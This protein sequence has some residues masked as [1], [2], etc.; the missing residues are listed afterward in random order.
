MDGV[1]KW[2]IP[3]LFDINSSQIHMSGLLVS[4]TPFHFPLPNPDVILNKIW[5]R[6]RPGRR[7]LL[8]D[9]A[10]IWSNKSLGET[11]TTGDAGGSFITVSLYRKDTTGFSS[12]RVCIPQAWMATRKA[13]A[14]SDDGDIELTGDKRQI[15]QVSLCPHSGRLAGIR[16]RMAP[17]GVHQIYELAIVDLLPPHIL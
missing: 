3:R 6:S 9:M 17:D 10:M 1:Y 8:P 5:Y 13:M 11:T 4:N 15:Y 16:V 12:T 2:P 7:D 14:W